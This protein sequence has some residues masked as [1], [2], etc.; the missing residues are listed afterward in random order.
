MSVKRAQKDIYD[1]IKKR[2]AEYNVRYALAVLLS[3]A[4]AIFFIFSI[5]PLIPYAIALYFGWDIV[6][7]WLVCVSTSILAFSQS[8]KLV[9]TL[10]AKYGITLEEK[11]FLRAYESLKFLEEYL[12]PQHPIMS[13]RMKA[14][15]KLERIYDLL[16]STEW[17]LPNVSIVREQAGQLAALQANL[18][19]RLMP[20]I[21]NIAPNREKDRATSETSRLALQA[22]VEYLTQ[23]EL[24][25]LT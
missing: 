23:P 17:S 7:V 8:S 13:S 1:Q 2:V 24:E 10:N 25:G 5:V 6:I 12:D 4:S 22:L 15:R 16:D 11:M 20:A 18:K 3:L 14:V 9:H 19:K 21:E